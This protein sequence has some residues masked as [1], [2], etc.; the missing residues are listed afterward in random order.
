MILYKK[1]F[2]ALYSKC[3]CQ[4]KTIVN[5]N[6]HIALLKINI[7]IVEKPISPFRKAGRLDN[8]QLLTNWTLDGT[9]YFTFLLCIHNDTMQSN[10][11]YAIFDSFVI[12]ST[13]FIFNLLKSRTENADHKRGR[14]QLLVGSV[15]ATKT[16]I[17]HSSL[18]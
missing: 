9:D 8:W 15:S 14:N 16:S 17:A 10:Y 3:M 18:V 13:I 11:L 4:I 12:K 6:I 2:I 7:I 1:S 5:F